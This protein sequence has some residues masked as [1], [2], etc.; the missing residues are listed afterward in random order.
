VP[1]KWD[2]LRMSRISGENVDNENPFVFSFDEL[3]GNDVTAIFRPYSLVCVA[4]SCG[5]DNQQI[6]EH[7][8]KS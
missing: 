8:A 3:C 4:V 5:D 6:L 7:L 1:V 2:R